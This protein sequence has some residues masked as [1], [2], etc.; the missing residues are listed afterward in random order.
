MPERIYIRVDTNLTVGMI[1][2]VN[3]DVRTTV[4]VHSSLPLSSFIHAISHAF[5][6]DHVVCVEY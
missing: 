4:Q 2:E 6:L 1:R 3:S 5:R